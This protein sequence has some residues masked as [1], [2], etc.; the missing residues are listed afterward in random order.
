MKTI[1]IV[2][3]REDNRALLMATLEPRDYRLVEASSGEEALKLIGKEEPDLIIADVL[4]PRMDG[5]EFVQQLRQ[6]PRNAQ[7]KV[8]FYTASYIEEESRR[9]AKACGVNHI[10]VKP[11]DPDTVLEIVDEALG[12]KSKPAAIV[13]TPDF[14]R[15][16]LH[17]VT[18]KLSEKVEELETLTHQL[19]QEIVERKSAE[20]ALRA[21]E[22]HL[23]TVVENLDEGVIVSDLKGGLVQW[24]RAALTI[25][26]Y[27]KL[28]E[29][30]RSQSDLVDTF[31]LSTLGGTRVPLEEWPLFRILRG[32]NL[33][34]L[35]L[36]VRNIRADWERIFNYG[37]TLVHDGS[38]EPVLAIVTVSDITQRKRVEERLREQADIINHARDA[39]IIR[40]F[41]DDRITFWNKG[42]EHLYGWTANEALGK[43]SGELLYADANERDA[44]LKVLLSTGEFH[45]ELKQVTKGARDIVVDCR[46]TLIRDPAGEPRSLLL[47]NT[48]IT[49][50]KKLEM[51]LLRAQRLESIGTLAGGVAHDLNNVL[52]PI[53]MGAES[54]R[55]N[56]TGEH[57]AAMISLIEESARRGSSIVKQVLTFARGVEGERVL[58]N[59]RHLIDEMVEIGKRTFPKTIEVTGK[60]PE[61][62]WAISG[63]PTQLHQVLLNLSMNARDAMGNGGSLILA[64]ENVEVDDNFAAMMPGAKAGSYATLRV[65][66][67]GVGIPRALVEKI[68]EPFFTTKD[69]GKGT[70]LG[71]STSLGIVK[72]HAGFISVS[73]EQGRGT[74]FTVF[75]PAVQA[76]VAPCRKEAPPV[77]KGNGELVLLVDDEMNVRRVAKMTLETHNY[78]V[79]EANDGPEAL[80]IFAQH[81]DSISVVLTDLIM[82]YIDGVALIRALKRIKPDM[83][84][85]ASS[86]QDAEP[87]LVELQ[88]LGVV[89]F[90]CKPYDTRKLLTVLE[91][92]VS[93]QLAPLPKK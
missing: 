35:E 62:P 27:T 78:C 88:G 44:P 39:I 93:K 61:H 50:Q 37:G 29:G 1:V 7:T 25:H 6:D 49:E 9:L 16:H 63:D 70:G 20:D 71:L 72:S 21:S 10:I 58:I 15:E 55:C 31:E 67:T 2:D 8:I 81:K 53:L 80:A 57:A 28:E 38:N 66:D 74:T 83:I 45:G 75:L 91:S 84:F 47:I 60:Y 48:D 64:A 12:E 65:S 18:D 82:P 26:G 42:A 59:P 51:Q 24:N 41:Q 77:T 40:H 33:R 92:A 14:E 69:P 43:P 22:A 56:R 11:T 23:Q 30:L 36:R 76:D 46:A 34:D 19:E 89:N 3:D 87:R 13:P 85:I 79:L 4:M 52:G 90:L 73:S 5:Y 86:G 54:L 68:F 32:E 17:L